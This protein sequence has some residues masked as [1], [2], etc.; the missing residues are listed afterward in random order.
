MLIQNEPSLAQSAKDYE[1][2]VAA[3]QRAILDSEHITNQQNIKVEVRKKIQDNC[4]ILREFDVYW[5]YELAGLTY[6]TVIECKHYSST[7]SVGEIDKLIGKAKDIPDLKLVFATTKGYQSGAKTKAKHN[8]IDLLLVREQNSS[9]WITQDGKS[10]V[11]KISINLTYCPPAQIIECQ[12]QIDNQWVRKNTNYDTSK[13]ITIAGRN[14]EIIIEDLKN[15]S[16]YS[17]Q[18]LE[19]RLA[20]LHGKTHG[21][22]KKTKYFDNAYIVHKSFRMKLNSLKISYQIHEPIT[23][24]IEIDYSKELLGVVEYLEKGHTFSVFKNGIVRT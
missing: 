3:L 9:D 10:L 18:E 5:E 8:K 19:S 4:G 13:P 15:S 23:E 6:K 21:R 24:T 11:K 20:P 14:D 22:F 16:T 7:V 1:L 12:S 17:L 2:F